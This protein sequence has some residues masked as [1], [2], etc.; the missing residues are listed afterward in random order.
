[1]LLHNINPVVTPYAVAENMKRNTVMSRIYL[2][3]LLLHFDGKYVLCSENWI[4][5]PIIHSH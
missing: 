1:M 3:E 5:V 4:H 2:N